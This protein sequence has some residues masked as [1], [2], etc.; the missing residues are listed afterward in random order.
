MVQ[1]K[2]LVMKN[3]ISQ[4]KLNNINQFLLAFYL[5]YLS[6]SKFLIGMLP[7]RSYYLLIVPSI[8]ILLASIFINFNKSILQKS[9][10]LSL[11]LASSLLMISMAFYWNKDVLLYTYNFLIFGAI[12]LILL[13]HIRTME[14]FFKYFAYFSILTIACLGLDPLNGY[15]FTGDYMV[16]GYFVMLPAYTGVYVARKYYKMKWLLPFEIV[17]LLLIIIYSNQGAV[18]SAFSLIILS[19]IL[20]DEIKIKKIVIFVIAISVLIAM[21]INFKPIIERSI[22]ITETNG[23]SSYSLLKTYGSIYEG[24]DSLS[25]RS[26]YWNEASTLF[27]KGPVLGNG[28][29]FFQSKY[30]TYTHNI[31]LEVAVSFGIFGITGSFLYILYFIAAMMKAAR[32]DRLLFVLG[33]TIGLVPLFFSLQPFIWCYFWVFTLNPWVNLRPNKLRELENA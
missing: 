17:A 29:G 3:S 16:F 11:L 27:K 26:Y 24:S 33:I 8:I 32:N 28:I 25:G 7:I 21:S 9:S 30:G 5:S 19:N 4:V 13:L 6:F 23:K 12:P 20:I 22:A 18:L 15:K 1:K 2:K 10:L 14:N 31:L